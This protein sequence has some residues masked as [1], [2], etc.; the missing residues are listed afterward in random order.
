M[1]LATYR[2]FSPGTQISSTY[3]TDRLD[4]IKILLKVALNNWRTL[5]SMY[6]I[7]TLTV[8]GILILVVGG[9]QDNFTCMNVLLNDY[10]GE[11]GL[12]DRKQYTSYGQIMQMKTSHVH[13]CKPLKLDYQLQCFEICILVGS[14]LLIVSCMPNVAIVS[15]LSILDCPVCFL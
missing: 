1:W 6:R 15:G 3:K 8:F 12:L 5:C 11:N 2:W 4:I 7:F 9:S 14:V 13:K 10:K